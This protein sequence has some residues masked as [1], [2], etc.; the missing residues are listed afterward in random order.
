MK[1]LEKT[2]PRTLN[3]QRARRKSFLQ[4]SWRF[5]IF[6][7]ESMSKTI[8]GPFAQIFTCPD[9]IFQF[10]I[11]LSTLPMKSTKMS[12]NGIQLWFL[13]FSR[14]HLTHLGTR[15]PS[16]YACFGHLK[17]FA[18][19]STET[20]RACQPRRSL[21]PPSLF[22][23]PTFHFRVYASFVEPHLRQVS[24]ISRHCL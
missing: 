16:Y 21:E 6:H 19:P 24:E 4:S 11:S 3:S 18:K 8:S 22:P 9:H 13:L 23:H 7:E 12:R 14:S 5:E 15:N 17:T 20:L 10:R 1:R 2:F